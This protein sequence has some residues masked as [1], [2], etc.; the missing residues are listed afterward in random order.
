MLE[1]CEKDDQGN[2][3]LQNKKIKTAN[4]NDPSQVLTNI[5]VKLGLVQVQTQATA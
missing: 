2:P 4:K 1:A 3:D 5:A